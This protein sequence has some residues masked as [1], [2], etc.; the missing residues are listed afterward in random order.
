M[1]QAVNNVLGASNKAVGPS[2][3]LTPSSLTCVGHPRLE[4]CRLTC[5]GQGLSSSIGPGYSGG[6][7][8]DA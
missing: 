2:P 3:L 4:G 5:S 1:A 7:R 8:A 6:R